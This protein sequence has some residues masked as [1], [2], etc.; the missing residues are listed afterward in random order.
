MSQIILVRH[1]EVKIDNPLIYSSQMKTWIEKYNTTAIDVTEISDELKTLV[2]NA[3]ILLT[4]GLSRTKETLKIFNKEPDYSHIVFNEAE[5]PYSDLTLFK[6]PANIWTIF[7]RIAW[8]LGYSN[9]SESYKEAKI[10]AEIA[11]D[12]LIDFT[13]QYK[14][15]LFVGHG[16]M[17]R[18]IIKALRKRGLVLKEKIGSGNLGYTIMESH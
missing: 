4:S 10:R 9:H 3:D 6:I 16:V 13:N 1:A 5:L 11:A 8:L 7:F 14:N 18:L 17:N 2:E 12:K 15:I